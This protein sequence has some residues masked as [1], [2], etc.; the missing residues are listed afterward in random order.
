MPR[1][2]VTTAAESLSCTHILPHSKQMQPY[3]R[4]S[5]AQTSQIGIDIDIDNASDKVELNRLLLNNLP[6]K[7]ETTAA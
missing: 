7:V 6:G 1:R 2:C 3:L 4:P 5:A